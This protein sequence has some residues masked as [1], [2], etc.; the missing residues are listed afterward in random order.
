M[1]SPFVVK[2]RPHNIVLGTGTAYPVAD[3]EIVSA[4][5]TRG[6]VLSVRT[7][8]GELITVCDWVLMKLKA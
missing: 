2:D 4:A 3:I 5:S 8:A 6:I 1:N 7:P